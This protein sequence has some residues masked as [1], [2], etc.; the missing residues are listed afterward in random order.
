MC[1]FDIIINKMVKS[2]INIFDCFNYLVVDIEML[3]NILIC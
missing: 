1:K 3:R 2:L